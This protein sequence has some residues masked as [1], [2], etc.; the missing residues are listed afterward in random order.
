[1]VSLCVPFSFSKV[2][3]LFFFKNDCITYWESFF[4]F[5]FTKCTN[6]L[7]FDVNRLFGFDF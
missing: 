5:F 3:D 6:H 2:L 7:G 1:M 4:F